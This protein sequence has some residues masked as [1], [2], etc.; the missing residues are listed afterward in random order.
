MA[1]IRV[2]PDDLASQIAAGEVVERPASIV[3]EL[4]ENALD[5]DATRIE[6]RIVAGGLA[7]LEVSDDGFGMAREDAQLCLLRHATS[8]LRAFSDLESLVSYGFRGEALP[9]IASVSRLTL[10][11][12]PVGEEAAIRIASAFGQSRDPETVGAP[13][14]T[15]VRIQELF[16]NVPARLK[17]LRS[18]NTEAAHVVD[19]FTQVALSRPAVTFVLERDGRQVRH[20]P[21]VSDR[22]ARAAQIFET[23]QFVMGE[24]ARGPLAIQAY[25]SLDA[26]SRAGAS[27]LK[28]LVNGRAV[29]DRG[30]A[31]AVAHAFGE[32]LPRGH[33]PAGV[34]YLD[35]SP[36]LV[37]VNVHPQKLE[38]RFADPR[39]VNEVLH[40]IV[41]R[42]LQPSRADSLGT[43]ETRAV[44]RT[45]PAAPQPNARRRS[46]W[47]S[48]QEIGR[49]AASLQLGEPTPSAASFSSPEPLPK[50]GPSSSPEPSPQSESS[51]SSGRLRF[52]AQLQ[53]SYLLAEG[54]DGIY[55]V[56]Q[57]STASRA[58]GQKL[59]RAF[60]EGTLRAQALLF[61]V[62]IALSEAEVSALLDR[63]Q[64]LLRLGLDVRVRTDHGVTLHSLPEPL[65]HVA[66]EAL[67]RLVTRELTPGPHAR[68]PNAKDAS[69]K[70]P[71][72]KEAPFHR[73]IVALANAF[74][75][76]AG[77]TVSAFAGQSLLNS[78]DDFSEGRRSDPRVLLRIGFEELERKLGP[79]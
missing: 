78:I 6:L 57:Y 19:V 2:L 79:K 29:R 73:A 4:L 30:L 59:R 26:A 14:G 22:K 68:P 23:E 34:V 49:A 41:T 76:K 20:Y 60:E 71:H 28:F 36:A 43:A 25:F 48:P 54:P 56:D 53:K 62:T 39:A 50:G 8:K 55:F 12:R 67:F 9:S 52:L 18:T 75:L 74:C 45:R 77:E 7:E 13:L 15:S 66:P 64:E 70:D 11:T 5:A 21:R 31:G 38:V 10:T 40:S 32:K 35:L 37:D 1:T 46:P 69:A 24:G 47:L 58:L 65:K 44:E 72:A 63:S 61:P 16:S 51:P 17:F 33:Y 27:R 3:K 42:A